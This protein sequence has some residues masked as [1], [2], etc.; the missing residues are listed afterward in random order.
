MRAIVDVFAV[1]AIT[2]GLLIALPAGGFADER[3]RLPGGAKEVEFDGM[4]VQMIPTDKGVFMVLGELTKG[5]PANVLLFEGAR[6]VQVKVT[7][8]D[9]TQVMVVHRAWEEELARQSP[10]QSTP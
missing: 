4:S 10:I 8:H 5:Q 3:V 7:P 2:L 9:H 1:T 6:P